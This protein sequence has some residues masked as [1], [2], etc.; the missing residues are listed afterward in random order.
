MWS[1]LR[2]NNTFGDIGGGACISFIQDSLLQSNEDFL[3]IFANWYT[4]QPASFRRL[5]AKGAFLVD[6]DQNSS[7]YVTYA[8][9]LS[10]KGKPCQV[11]NPWG[12]IPMDVFEDGVPLDDEKI[13]ISQKS[14]GSVYKFDTKP[15]SVCELKTTE[16]DFLELGV[17]ISLEVG[18]IGQ[19][20]VFTD[21]DQ[22]ELTWT[23]S[24][25]N[26]V[27]V[28]ATRFVAAIS[29]GEATVTATHKDGISDTCLV[30]V[31]A[32]Q[33]YDVAEKKPA[34]DSSHHDIYDASMAVSGDWTPDYHGWAIANTSWAGDPLRWIS[35]DLGQLYKI[36][37]WV[38]HLEGFR[39]GSD[40]TATGR[41]S[42][43]LGVYMLQVSDN[44]VDGWETLDFQDDAPQ[45]TTNLVDKALAEPKEGRYFRVLAD[46]TKYLATTGGYPTGFVRIHQFELFGT[47]APSIEIKESAPINADYGTPFESLIL[48]EKALVKV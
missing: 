12:K 42:G 3:N 40:K 26:V 43:N 34:K 33:V 18:E 23:S 35:V 16:G 32:A 31:S 37:R 48:P 8:S 47:P 27:L 15:G 38:L 5:R 45:Y 25:A 2:G 7:G 13:E 39:S 4:N 11:L 41:Y 14:L 19:I 22:S 44:G 9:I 20:E 28:N 17:D 10:E 30:K 36:D 21:F 46:V 24:D 1:G 29:E 6:A